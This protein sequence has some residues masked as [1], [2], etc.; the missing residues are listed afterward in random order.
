[1]IFVLA[2]AKTKLNLLTPG[3]SGNQVGTC[4]NGF[5]YQRNKYKRTVN[6]NV[7]VQFFELN[8]N[9]KENFLINMAYFETFVS[10]NYQT[11]ATG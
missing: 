8:V 7:H 3:A 6:K 4:G 2:T 10:I 11:M 9:V 5:T 1:M